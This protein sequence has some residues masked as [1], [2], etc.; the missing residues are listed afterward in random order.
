MSS[1]T[2]TVKPSTPPQLLPAL[3]S[4]FYLQPTA[5]VARQLLGKLLLHHSAAGWVGG[6]IVETEAYLGA[7]DPASHTYR[8]PT[9]RN[10]AM[11]GPPGTSYVYFTYGMHYCLNAVTQK[12]G[13]GEAVLIRALEPTVGLPLM[14]QRRGLR[15]PRQLCNGPAK[16]VQ[17]LGVSI[18]QSGDSL[19]R[20]ELTIR[21]CGIPVSSATSTRIG[22]TRARQL[23]LRFFIPSNPHVSRT[24]PPRA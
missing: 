21:D 15:D 17:A 4:R 5:T 11:F 18:N 2:A 1:S 19:S 9:L 13:I 24:A 7:A 10:R 8:G 14:L 20:S 23:P 6:L 3:S 16:L 22:I 12:P